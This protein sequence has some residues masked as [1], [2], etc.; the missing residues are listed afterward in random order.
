MKKIILSFIL[1][2]VFA[3]VLACAWAM[4]WIDSQK[5]NYHFFKQPQN[6][7]QLDIVKTIWQMT[8]ALNSKKDK[9]RALKISE[10]YISS[11]SVYS[12]KEEMMRILKDN[13]QFIS[14]YRK[15]MPTIYKLIM[16]NRS[17]GEIED[18]KFKNDF[19]NYMVLKP[20]P[21]NPVANFRGFTE[22]S[23]FYYF[24]HSKDKSY[25]NISHSILEEIAE[26][27][28]D[29]SVYIIDDYHIGLNLC[30]DKYLSKENAEEHNIESQKIFQ[31]MQQKLTKN[32]REYK[33]LSDYLNDK[34]L[35]ALM[36]TPLISSNQTECEK[37]VKNFADKMV[38]LDNN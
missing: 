1:F 33:I 17:L 23:W 29:L 38:E 26:T 21:E 18:S 16:I 10:L 7:K 2:S 11:L 36:L 8:P 35:S 13:Y 25:W 9:D 37:E 31:Q 19:S 3:Y 30:Y 28:N 14:Q 15:D 5:V 27:N 32:S 24:H 22:Q 6:T 20:N 4:N 34:Y 12:D